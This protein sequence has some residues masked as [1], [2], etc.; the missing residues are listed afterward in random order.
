VTSTAT[1]K[2]TSNITRQ[3]PP[4]DVNEDGKVDIL[5]LVLVGRYFGESSPANPRADV[6]QDGIVDIVDL[7]LIG[8][9]FGEV[10]DYAVTFSNN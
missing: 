5:D 3:S 10:I 4:W 7:T 8:V 2:V 1:L 9:H 6:N